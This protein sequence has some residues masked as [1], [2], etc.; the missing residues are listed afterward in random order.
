MFGRSGRL[1]KPE[2]SELTA[3]TDK[4]SSA[5][6]STSAIGN[7]LAGSLSC[8]TTAPRIVRGAITLGRDQPVIGNFAIAT[9]NTAKPAAASATFL[10]TLMNHLEC[11]SWP[12]NHK[13]MCEGHFPATQLRV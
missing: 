8:S 6:T 2:L 3:E 4:L 1:K 13:S 5:V 7:C 10:V 12:A 11:Y 9:A